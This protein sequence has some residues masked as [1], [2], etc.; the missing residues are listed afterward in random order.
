MEPTLEGLALRRNSRNI[1]GRRGSTKP[2]R[3][4]PWDDNPR[5][6]RHAT[7]AAAKQTPASRKKRRRFANQRPMRS[8]EP[9]KPP[10]LLRHS[11]RCRR[12]PLQGCVPGGGN[13]SATVL[14]AP[15]QLKP[16]PIPSRKRKDAKPRTV[17][18]KPVRILT[19]DQNTTASASP[20]AAFPWR[21]EKCHPAAT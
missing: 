12:W 20:K 16:S 7:T 9:T 1:L 3:A 19:T 11:S 17:E 4:S 6:G 15:G 18:A 10:R 21:R 8:K 13:H 14:L 2:P 5:D